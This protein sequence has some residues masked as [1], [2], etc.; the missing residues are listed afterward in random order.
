MMKEEHAAGA[1][2]SREKGA[3]NSELWGGEQGEARQDGMRRLCKLAA[4]AIAK[5]SIYSSYVPFA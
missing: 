4:R 1:A 3:W 5:N 2:A